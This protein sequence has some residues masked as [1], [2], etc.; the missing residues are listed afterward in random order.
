MALGSAQ[1]PE[2]MST[3]NIPEGKGGRCV[4]LTTSSPPSAEC[5]EIWEP[6]PPG[7]LWATPGLLQD[8][9]TFTFLY[10]GIWYKD[11]SDMLGFFL[12]II[13]VLF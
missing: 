6:K 10:T 2:K 8:S 13:I 11:I 4:R 12:Q 3:K 5:H 1:P 7:T 9:F